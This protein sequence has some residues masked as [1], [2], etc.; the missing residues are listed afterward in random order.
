LLGIAC[1]RGDGAACGLG[2]H[3]RIWLSEHDAARAFRTMH[4][5]CARG[6]GE[7][8]AVQLGVEFVPNGSCGESCQAENRA[9]ALRGCASGSLAACGSAA[10]P[11][12][13]ETCDREDSRAACRAKLEA[14]ATD[15]DPALRDAYRKVLAACDEGDADACDAI[16]GHAFPAAELCTA[17]DYRACAEAA[18]AGD[19]ASGRRG[20]TEGQH[21]TACRHTGLLLRD[22]ATDRSAEAR[23]FLQQAC[24]ARDV[25]ACEAMRHPDFANGCAAHK[26]KRFDAATAARL[27]PFDGLDADGTP[28]RLQDPD[29]K[30]V[31]LLRGETEFHDLLV[32][33]AR[34]ARG[35][36][37]LLLTDEALEPVEGARVVTVE[38]WRQ[39]IPAEVVV[40]DGGGRIRARANLGRDAEDRPSPSLPRCVAALLGDLN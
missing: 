23:R 16:R 8:C 11:F 7:A 3:Q 24:D 1:H 20:C 32:E 38:L 39:P 25:T 27:E 6:D 34:A 19:E 5:A 14:A 2:F 9:L 13:R 31:V 33:V 17:G 26:A 10:H 18:E 30:P 35:A 29:G 15:E 28:F 36:N 21:P 4:D 12:L 37:V 22:A 40:L